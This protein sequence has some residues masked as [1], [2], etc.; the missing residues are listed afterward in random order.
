MPAPLIDYSECLRDSP[1]FRQ[2]LAQNESSL[3]ELELRLEKVI[4]LLTSSSSRPPA[5]FRR[6]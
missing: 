2:Q 6:C 3:E 1:K 5:S 4:L